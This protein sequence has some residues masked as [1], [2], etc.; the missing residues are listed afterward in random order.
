MVKLILQ[1]QDEYDRCEH[2]KIA[3][4]K[5][6]I[7]RIRDVITG[8]WDECHISEEERTGFV[9]YFD[10]DFNEELLEAHEEEEKRLRQYF[11]ETKYELLYK[12]GLLTRS[13]EHT[14]HLTQALANLLTTSSQS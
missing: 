6:V 12:Y 11:E 7:L 1:W 2:L 9:A 14:S 3:N 10:D 13:V 8:L 4:M 5:K